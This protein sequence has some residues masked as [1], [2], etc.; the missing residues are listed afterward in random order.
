MGYLTSKEIRHIL[1]DCS[2]ATLW[3]YQQPNQK[4]FGN[5]LPQPIKKGAGSPSLWDEKTFR[6]W[7]NKYFKNNVES[8]TI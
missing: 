5:P 4:L 8:L 6:E 3:R 7:E 1:K 2:A